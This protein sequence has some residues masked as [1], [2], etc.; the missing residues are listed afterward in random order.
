MLDDYKILGMAK[1]YGKDNNHYLLFL[2]QKNSTFVAVTR[3]EYENVVKT[4]DFDDFNDAMTYCNDVIEHESQETEYEGRKSRIGR[5]FVE[6]EKGIEKMWMYSTNRNYYRES[7]LIDEIRKTITSGKYPELEVVVKGYYSEKYTVKDFTPEGVDLLA[8]NVVLPAKILNKYGMLKIKDYYKIYSLTAPVSS[9]NTHQIKRQIELISQMLPNVRSEK[10]R[11]FYEKRIKKLHEKIGSK[12]DIQDI[13]GK[14]ELD[15]IN[16]QLKEI[17]GRKTELLGE[18][19]EYRQSGT[20]RVAGGLLDTAG[21][22]LIRLKETERDLK[23]KRDALLEKM[24]PTGSKNVTNRASNGKDISLHAGN[25]GLDMHVEKGKAFILGIETT[26]ENR[27]KGEGTKLMESLVKYLD[28]NRLE[29]SLTASKVDAD[30]DMKRLVNFYSR[31]G[32]EVMDDTDE[33]NVLMA[34]FIK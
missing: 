27:M 33:D 12:A 4:K 9:M 25:S 30:T 8:I 29:C 26:K 2:F 22:D 10:K 28:K 15:E 7:E 19:K 18:Q 31:F 34:R 20:F 21:Y 32:F 5:W 23:K 16:R 14:S 1:Y 17:R 6:H 11:A 24:K 3:Q 13:K